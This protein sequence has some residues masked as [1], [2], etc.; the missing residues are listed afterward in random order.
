MDKP[1]KPGQPFKIQTC[2]IPTLTR[3]RY[4]RINMITEVMPGDGGLDTK[5]ETTTA[6]DFCQAMHLSPLSSATFDHPY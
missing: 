5:L 1:Y 6:T 2:W 3:G 4:L